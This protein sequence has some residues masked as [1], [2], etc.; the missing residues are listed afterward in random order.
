VN[1]R[2]TIGVGAIDNNGKQSYYSEPCSAMLVTAPSSGN[3]VGITTTDLLGSRGYSATDCTATFGGTSSACPLVAG[4][5]ALMLQAN[6]N[7]TWLDV[8]HILVQTADQNDPTDPDWTV[9]GAGLLINHKYGF[10]RVNATA[11]VQSAISFPSLP[12]TSKYS[13]TNLIVNQ[14]IPDGQTNGTSHTVLIEI[15]GVTLD[16]V[17]VTVNIPDFVS[18]G[19]LIIILT[20]PSGTQSVLAE[21]HAYG[22]ELT[23]SLPVIDPLNEIYVLPALFGPTI[24]SPINGTLA[25]PLPPD[26]CDVIT[27]CAELQG[28]LA[29]VNRSQN[30][31][32]TDQVYRM[33]ECGSIAVVVV[34]NVAGGPQTMPGSNPNITIPSVMISLDDGEDIIAY[35]QNA[36]VVFL[37]N[38]TQWRYDVDFT[39]WTF[40]TVRNWGEAAHGN[41]TIEVID[42]YPGGLQGHFASWDLHLYGYQPVED[43]ENFPWKW[44]IIG[45]VGSVFVVAILAVGL[46]VHSR[47]RVH[48]NALR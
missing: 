14:S 7:L 19:D 30:C 47:R 44:V 18:G 27:N 32:F 15:L 45:V 10:G 29:L 34:N 42:V 4:V 9:N 40:S 5:I 39:N 41:W 21:E 48:Y 2:L 8:Q 46:F 24:H 25:A 35:M 23:A 38:A 26:A 36:I 3:G 13:F 17:E 16:H 37:I 22:V 31:N 33:Q 20:S 1:S 43:A 28:Q 6:P 12:Q 11:A